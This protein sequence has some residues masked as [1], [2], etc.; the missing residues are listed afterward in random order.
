[1][2]LASRSG[3]LFSFFSS[4]LERGFPARLRLIRTSENGCELRSQT[5]LCMTMW[6]E[7]RSVTSRT[8]RCGTSFSAI[9]R[10]AHQLA[11]CYVVSASGGERVQ[12]HRSQ[13][14]VLKSLES[15]DTCACRCD[16][17]C[18]VLPFANSTCLT[19]PSQPS[20]ANLLVPGRITSSRNRF[21]S[22]NTSLYSTSTPLDVA[23]I[24]DGLPHTRSRGT[25]SYRTPIA[26]LLPY[27]ATC[28]FSAEP[29]QRARLT[30]ATALRGDDSSMAVRRRSSVAH[31]IS[32]VRAAGQTPHD[33]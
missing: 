18:N 27:P 21:L 3:A 22:P 28:A 7:L 12:R 14:H 30:V 11:F 4:N 29:N 17:S 25:R 19:C 15:L 32:H 5:P 9:A 16:T 23:D 31:A 20:L 26:C 13:T 2:S 24:G 8:R 1:M 10:C 33:H 6:V